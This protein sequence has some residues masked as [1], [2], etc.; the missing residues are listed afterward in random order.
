LD[1]QKKL[2][3]QTRGLT[4]PAHVVALG[5][6]QKV[7]VAVSWT[8]VVLVAGGRTKV[9]YFVTTMVLGTE[10]VTLGE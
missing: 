5:G 4:P 9:V 10:T 7:D 3:S 8:V 1:V 2:G 6:A